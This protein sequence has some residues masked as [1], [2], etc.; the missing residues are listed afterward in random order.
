[1]RSLRF[2][3]GAYSQEGTERK[4]DEVNDGLAPALMLWTGA[5]LSISLYLIAIAL[6]TPVAPFAAPETARETLA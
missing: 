1:L 3:F 2:A 6:V 5:T 4:C